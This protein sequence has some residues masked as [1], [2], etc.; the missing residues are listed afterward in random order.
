MQIKAQQ[1]TISY[2]IMLRFSVF[3]RVSNLQSKIYDTDIEKAVPLERLY[4]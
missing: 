2:I 1:R 4:G 3:D